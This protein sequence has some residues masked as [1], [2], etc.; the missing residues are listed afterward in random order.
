MR[1]AVL[2][3]VCENDTH[4]FC[5]SHE[6]RWR[7]LGRPAVEDYVA[8]CLLRGRARIDFRGLARSPDCCSTAS[9]AATTSRRS[10]RRRRW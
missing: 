2:H 4:L 3:A 8:H 1:A 10:P 5:K 9:S 7:Q 6:T